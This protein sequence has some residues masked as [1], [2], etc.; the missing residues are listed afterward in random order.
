[1][2]GVEPYDP[3]PA[4]G[5]LDGDEELLRE[6]IGL[7]HEEWLEKSEMIEDALLQAD[8][9]AL[10]TAAHFLKGAVGQLFSDGAAAGLVQVESS[11]RAG[12]LAAAEDTWRSDVPKVESMLAA[13]RS[14][15][16]QPLEE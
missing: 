14:W 7:V 3:G 4:L 16:G 10:A 6:V 11:A 5:R 9:A 1:V 8:T 12:D 15:A 13:A 2:S